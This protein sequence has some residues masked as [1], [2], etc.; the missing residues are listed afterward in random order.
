MTETEQIVAW[1][2][3]DV[4]DEA[5]RMMLAA[6]LPGGTRTQRT[7]N[8]AFADGMAHAVKMIREGIERGEHAPRV[9]LRKGK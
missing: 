9:E 7:K 6:G 8:A 1:L 3:R 5:M 4:A 2:K